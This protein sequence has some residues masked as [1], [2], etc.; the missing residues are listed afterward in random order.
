MVTILSMVRVCTHSFKIIGTA[1]EDEPFNIGPS[2]PSEQSRDN[3]RK[4]ALTRDT[5]SLS[6]TVV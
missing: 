3:M 2:V 5:H 1:S 6:F 4:Y